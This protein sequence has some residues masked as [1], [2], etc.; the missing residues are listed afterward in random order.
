MSGNEQNPYQGETGV[1]ERC[2]SVMMESATAAACPTHALG[3]EVDDLASRRV[4]TRPTYLEISSEG[5]LGNPFF[6]SRTGRERRNATGLSDIPGVHYLA[7]MGTDVATTPPVP[8]T[9]ALSTKEAPRAFI[10][11][12][13]DFPTEE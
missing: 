4:T 6:P 13:S 8:R 7:L 11:P 1:L 9:G 3:A 10:G 12:E 5:P 2:S